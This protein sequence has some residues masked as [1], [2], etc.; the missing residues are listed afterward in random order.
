MTCHDT[1]FQLPTS[2]CRSC[3]PAAVA[4]IAA[5][6]SIA[7]VLPIVTNIVAS[8]RALNAQR[9]LNRCGARRNAEYAKL[10][11]SRAEGW[12]SMP[13]RY[14]LV[15]LRLFIHVAEAANITR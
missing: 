5:K 14:D 8:L 7:A 9:K 13:F 10:A 4:M 1:S 6:P 11:S 12:L 2:G 3:T 15:D